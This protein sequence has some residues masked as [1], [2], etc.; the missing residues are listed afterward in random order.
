MLARATLVLPWGEQARMALPVSAPSVTL[1]VPV[2]EIGPGPER[3][4]DVLAYAGYP[5]KRGLDILCLAWIEAA[6]PASGF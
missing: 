5:D 2:E 3:D 6:R 4:I 1:P